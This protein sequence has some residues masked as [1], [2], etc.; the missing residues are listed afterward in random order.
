MVKGIKAIKDLV[1]RVFDNTDR[2]EKLEKAHTSTVHEIL[3]LENID[4]LVDFLLKVRHIE[5]QHGKYRLVEI[6]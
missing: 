2:I 4:T 5:T 6:K 1:N 3:G